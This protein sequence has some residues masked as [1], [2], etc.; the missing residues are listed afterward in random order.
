M[1]NSQQTWRQLFIDNI[2]LSRNWRLGKSK[3]L[4]CAK[5]TDRILCVCINTEESLCASGS[6]DHTIKVWRLTDGRLLNTIQE[7]AVGFFMYVHVCT[8]CTCIS[9]YRGC[10]H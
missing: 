8:L 5:H 4:S 9:Y 7:H 6:N 10:G 1:H 2:K 3:M